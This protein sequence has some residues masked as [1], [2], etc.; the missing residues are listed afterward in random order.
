VTDIHGNVSECTQVIKVVD[1]ELPTIECPADI[2]QTADAGVC[3]AQVT[4]PA[5]DVADN[6]QVASVVNDYNNTANA[7]DVYPV[8]ET[9]ITWT[10]TDIYGNE[11]TCEMTVTIT[12]DEL[13]IATCGDSISVYNDLGLCEAFVIVTAPSTSDN[14][15]VASVINDYN[16]TAN[17][18][19]VYPVGPTTITWTVTD[20]AGNENTCTQTITVVDNEQ[21]EIICPLAITVN[22]DADSCNA[23]IQV[24]AITA[25]DNCG[26]ATIVNDYTETDDAS[27]VYPVGTTTVI[28]TVTDIHGNVSECTQV[29]KVVDP[30]LPTIECPADITQTADAGVCEAQVTV[31]APDVAD[32]C[33]VA[34]VVNDYNNTANASDVYPVGETIITWTVT[35]IYGNEASCQMTVTI[36]DDELPIATCGDSISVYNDLG[37]CEAFVIVTA[38]TTSD[39][40]AVASVIND[41]NNTANA[42][43]VYPVGPTTITWTVT[44]LAGN[45]NTCT[46]TITVVD[47]EQP[48]ITCPLAITVNNDADSCNAFILVPA[49]TAA[50][51][52]G[53]ATI[54]NDY[55]DTD[56]ASAVYPVGTTTVIWTVTDIHGNV[57]ECTQV[58][59]VVDP[60]LP[61]IECPADITQTADAGVCEAQVTVPAPDVADNC[62]VASVVNDYNNTV[63][64]SDVYPVGETII[65]WTVT[66]IYGN[67]AS[68]QMT[69]TITDDELPTIV[70]PSDTVTTTDAGVCEAFVTI[71]T[72]VIAD[73]CAVDYITNDWTNTANAS[74]IYPEG[75]TLVLW[76]VV[77]IHGNENTCTQVITV[78]D[79][80]NPVITC[81]A[82][83]T[84]P[85]DAGACEAL[86]NVTAM[87]ATDNCEIATIV[88]DYTETEDA[89]AVYPQGST[90]VTWTITDIH[91]N[92]STCVQTIVV[93]D[94]EAPVFTCP[95]DITVSNDTTT[96]GAFVEMIDVTATDNC[97][98]LSITNNRTNSANGTDTYPVGPTQ[99]TW[100]VTDIHGNVS[101][102]EQ[103]IVVTDN[104]APTIEC[105]GDIIQTADAGQCLAAVAVDA[106]IVDDNCQVA[107]VVNDYNDSADA[108]DVYPVGN[109]IVTWTVT[110][111]HGNTATCEM[112]ITVTDDEAPAINCP[113]NV[114]GF[115]DPNECGAVMNVAQPVV[116]DN[117]GIA[118]VVNDY[119]NTDNATD[120]YPVGETI[121]KW[122]VTD[123][124]GNVS[125]CSMLVTVNDNQIPEFVCPANVTVMS[126][127]GS[128]GAQVEI[129]IAQASDNCAVLSVLN[130]INDTDNAS[131]YY[132]VGSTTVTW[133]VF[134]IHGNTNICM[135]TVTVVDNE[136]PSIVCPVNI[137]QTADSGL[138]QAYITVEMPVVA[139]N[140][141]VAS[142]V[143]DFNDTDN[144]TDNY[145]VGETTVV[146]TVTDIHGNN[147]TCEMTVV[148]TDDELPT[149]ICPEDVLTNTDASVCEAAIA[150][151]TPV[152]NDN[153]AV[154][155]VINDY[156]G[157]S[158]ATDVYP[159][160]TTIIEWTVTDI[161]GNITTC[162]QTVVVVDNEAPIA[163]NCGYNVEVNNDEGECGAVVIYEIPTVTD[164][165]A[166][167]D[168]V[169][170]AGLASG[171]MFPIG[172]TEVIYE[173]F[174]TEGNSTTCNF[175]VV[176][177]DNELPVITC[178]ENIVLNNDLGVCGATVV[179][180][181]PEYSDNCDN[182]GV[183]LE[184][185]AGFDSGS[186]F[187]IG[188]TEV[189][190]TVTD[191]SGNSTDCTFTV[192][193]VDNEAPI[194]VCPEDIEQIDAIVNYTLP[195][196]SDNCTAT[197]TLIEGLESGDVFPHGYTTV[198]YVATDLAGNADTCSFAVLINTPPVAATDGAEF[199]E[200]DRCITISLIG[201]DYDIDSDDI[202]I[203]FIGETVGGTATLND[204]GTINY[205]VNTQE[206]CG[207]DSLNYVLCDSYGACDTGIVFIDVECYLYVIIPE[208]FSPNNDGSNDV[209]EIIGLEDY[210]NNH[211][212]IFNRW[213]HKVYEKKGYNNSWDGHSDAPLTMGSGMLPKG[214][215]FYILTLGDDSKPFKGSI[216]LNR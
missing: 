147:T 140:C 196:F 67:E 98:I 167:I 165:C 66:D 163:A 57:S 124:H 95:A 211:L 115:N 203:S 81:P 73:N 33:Q 113:V 28:W 213:G 38:P 118:S 78:N 93:N 143:N 177:T 1:P 216:F 10:V 7:S 26:I 179:Y 13:P 2:T 134:D 6:C 59:K 58:I 128:C 40:C 62:Q 121:I 195:V 22:N 32:N 68:R 36:T 44:D 172:T 3:E 5:P 162:T 82:N 152:V 34:S 41:Y 133:I 175:F 54:V 150:I 37:L 102:C 88:N 180:E 50:D 99:I 137:E 209:F 43:D 178:P 157:T 84:V 132:E 190:Y 142:V 92:E 111:I 174:D 122:T 136:A 123:I 141:E 131:G 21:P 183:T 20:L 185:N 109:T 46:Q 108:S 155:T 201:N 126:D 186:V 159:T 74:A 39:N 120:V 55:T 130:T 107:S 181:L 63:N 17:A 125:E 104:E 215:Y 65:T 76:T 144:A 214:T 208:A 12:D 90:T 205:C 103:T 106:P 139:D 116:N 202:S 117:C 53:I 25:A 9:I 24:P 105:P 97:G 129:P 148:V 35:D 182:A 176:V 189:T 14:C 164:N 31:P 188:V 72:P 151:A 173:F 91:G 170:N 47:N 71:G 161:H 187:P 138:C 206:W 127:E 80:E 145:P 42:S 171:S 75:T 49:I 207:I 119:N 69:I 51:N 114:T 199:L 29:I 48:V 158:N 153:C 64:A 60:E 100:T 18:S 149:L 23:F 184:L 197:L 19:D 166:V 4:V 160:G 204:D 87:V 156:N 85:T 77:D 198:T 15:A 27:A 135:Q 146:W 210:P 101:T 11:A 16:N 86:V 191:A 194:I 89:T 8:G 200:D 154:A 168:T 56:D 94:L 112:N 96:C 169:M 212:V 193:V 45:E 110:D 30:E 192:T 79:E 52:C 70:C 83:I 61:T